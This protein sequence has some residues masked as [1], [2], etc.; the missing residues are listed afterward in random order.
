MN[1]KLV[2]RMENL[3]QD[4]Y[5]YNTACLKI[6]DGNSFA[7]VYAE[8]TAFVKETVNE[9]GCI[10]FFAAPAS[11]DQGE[12][13]LWEVWEKEADMQK[14]MEQGHTQNLLAKNLLTLLWS[15]SVMV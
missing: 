5:F 11:V 9:D 4:S 8:L 3:P 14:H 12:I 2:N 6:T 13:M 15:K 1:N 10:E 7:Q